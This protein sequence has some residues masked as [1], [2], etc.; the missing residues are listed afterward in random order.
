M[1]DTDGLDPALAAAIAAAEAAV[2]GMAEDYAAELTASAASLAAAADALAAHAP[3]TPG[4]A[5]AL[6]DAFRITHDVKGQAGSFGFGAAGDLADALCERLRIVSCADGDLIAALRTA[7]R[8]LEA[9][10]AGDAGAAARAE[11][12][13]AQ[14]AG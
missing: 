3:G 7:A 8:L 14:V 4:H 9:M 10:A 12:L 11:A 13:A 2:A 5:D 1:A 6:A